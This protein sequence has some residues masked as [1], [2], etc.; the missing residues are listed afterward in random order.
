MPMDTED[1]AVTSPARNERG[2]VVTL[3]PDPGNA[4]NHE[5][6]TRRELA[7]RLAMLRDEAFEGEFDPERP[8]TAHR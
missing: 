7:R 5:T 6:M 4:R 2:V 8:C 3:M 1:P